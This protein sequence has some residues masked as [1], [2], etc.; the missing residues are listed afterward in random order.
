[1]TEERIVHCRKLKRDL[2]GLKRQP[3]RN[4]LG[5]RIY[6]E[7]SQEAWDMWLKDS[8][9]YIN[10][11]CGPG[12]KYDLATPEGQ[13]FMFEQISIYFGFEQGELA[14]TAFVPKDESK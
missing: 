4:E 9:K 1:M 13:R 5:R 7:V 8:V 11:Y 3:Y 10:T 12:S 2:P 14:K 6:E